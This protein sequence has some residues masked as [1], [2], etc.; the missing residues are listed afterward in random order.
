MN[1]DG[2]NNSYDIN[3]FFEK[4]NILPPFSQNLDL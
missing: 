1:Y 3:S 2:E 4:N